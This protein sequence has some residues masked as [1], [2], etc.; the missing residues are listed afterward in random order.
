MRAT[1]WVDLKDIMVN[2]QNESQDIP[3]FIVPLM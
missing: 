2:E 1:T 3:Y